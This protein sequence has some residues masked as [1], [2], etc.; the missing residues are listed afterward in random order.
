[1]RRQIKPVVHYTQ[2]TIAQI[3][4]RGSFYSKTF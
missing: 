4:H 2:I 3:W 1:M